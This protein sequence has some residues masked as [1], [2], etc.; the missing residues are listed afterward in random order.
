M[1][2]THIGRH[3]SVRSGDLQLK[4]AASRRARRE[5]DIDRVNHRLLAATFGSQPLSHLEVSTPAS[6]SRIAGSVVLGAR[7]DRTSSR[8]MAEATT[9]A[10]QGTTNRSVRW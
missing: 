8:R 5:S 7:G 9:D 6:F 4:V 10:S 3:R 2:A 1:A